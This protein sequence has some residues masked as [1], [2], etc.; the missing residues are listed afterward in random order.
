MNKYFVFQKKNNV[1]ADKIMQN[2]MKKK[3]EEVNLLEEP[4]EE[5]PKE[6]PKES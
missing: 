3:P 5:E 4:K 6:E 1:N 2:I